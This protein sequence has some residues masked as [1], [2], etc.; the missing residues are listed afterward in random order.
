MDILRRVFWFINRFFMVPGFRLGFGAL[1]CNPVSGYIMVIKNTGRK[2]G[3]LYFTPTNYAIQ[4]GHIYCMAGFG[5]SSDWYL[6]LSARPQAE[7]L[8]PGKSVACQ[9]EEV[10]DPDEALTACKQIFKNAGFAG[11]MEGFNPWRAPDERFLKTLQ[12]VPILRFKPTSIASGAT[13]AGGWHWI[14]LLIVL[15]IILVKIF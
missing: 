11:F 13:D 5:R 1:I 10:S 15:G 4:D 12:R 14:T 3:K 8:L 6:N 9:M 7:L 2:S